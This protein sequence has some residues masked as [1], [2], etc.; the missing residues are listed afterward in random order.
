MRAILSMWMVTAGMAVA[1]PVPGPGLP[2]PMEETLE[3]NPVRY[4]P[5]WEM[6]E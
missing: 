6:M 3:I 1:Q 2:G 4:L 5:E